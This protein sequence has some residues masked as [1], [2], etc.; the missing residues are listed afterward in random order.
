MD[1][2]AKSA[3]QG[4]GCGGSS[5][6]CLSLRPIGRDARPAIPALRQALN[7]VDQQVHNAAR[8]ALDKLDRPKKP[9]QP[10]AQNR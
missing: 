6:R 5:Q 2:Y 1:K 3:S 8:Y 9:Q 7:D 4:L 10:V